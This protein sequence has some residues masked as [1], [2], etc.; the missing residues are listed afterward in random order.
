MNLPPLS[1][2]VWQLSILFDHY[3]VLECY[4]VF[5]LSFYWDKI[6]KSLKKMRK[7]LKKYNI[8]SL[9]SDN[10][11]DILTI[12][13]EYELTDEEQIGV[14]KVRSRVKGTADRSNSICKRLDLR[15]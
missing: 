2:N 6:K 4:N 8:Y 9:T 11:D 15:I 10:F 3:L 1:K 7:E 14:S 12:T 5:I 13:K